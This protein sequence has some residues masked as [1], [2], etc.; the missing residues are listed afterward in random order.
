VE[1]GLDILERRR[2]ATNCQLL[3]S[4]RPNSSIEVSEELEGRRRANSLLKL[5]AARDK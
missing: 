4:Y 1:R 3:N 2:S 5:A